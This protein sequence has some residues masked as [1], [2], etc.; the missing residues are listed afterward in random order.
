MKAESARSEI[1]NVV[2]EM[3]NEKYSNKVQKIRKNMTT[4]NKEV[5]DRFMGTRVPDPTRAL[6]LYFDAKKTRD[7]DRAIAEAAENGRNVSSSYKDEMMDAR[8]SDSKPQPKPG[9]EV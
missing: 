7:M 1:R 8:F 6:P 2:A 4:F 5:G 9:V 3:D